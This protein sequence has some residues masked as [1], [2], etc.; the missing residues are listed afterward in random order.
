M[1][2]ARPAFVPL[3]ATY[4]C[5]KCFSTWIIRLAFLQDRR[6][7]LVKYEIIRKLVAE[8]CF[9]FAKYASEHD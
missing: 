6:K 3:V 5:K 2:T 1:F 4:T 9:F 7:E 8:F